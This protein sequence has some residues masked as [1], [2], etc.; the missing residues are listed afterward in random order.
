MNSRRRKRRIE[1]TDSDSEREECVLERDTLMAQADSIWDVIEWGFY[2][3][4]AGG[5]WSDLLVLIVRI[6]GNDLEEAN[7]GL[8]PLFV[9]RGS[10]GR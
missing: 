8:D 9:F 2:R 10:D 3:S 4:E 6:L 5:G 1:E 7:K